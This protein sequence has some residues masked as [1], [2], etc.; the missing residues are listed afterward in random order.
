MPF[1]LLSIQFFAIYCTLSDGW[2]L[3][4]TAVQLGHPSAKGVYEFEL[5]VEPKL[6]MSVEHEH[7]ELSIHDYEPDGM[8][9]TEREKSQLR[10]C[11][12]HHKLLSVSPSTAHRQQQNRSSVLRELAL[13]A[14][15]ALPGLIQFNGRHNRLS[16]V[17]GQ[18]PGPTLVVPEGAE[19][20]IRLKNRLLLE[21]LAIHFHGQTMNNSWFHDGVAPIQQC[22]VA[23]R[24]DFDF[25]FTAHPAGTH[26]YHGHFP[27]GHQSDG[28]VGAFIVLPKVQQRQRQFQ[29]DYVTILQDWPLVSS[30]EQEAQMEEGSADF[31][32]GVHGDFDGKHL[33]RSGK[34]NGTWTILIN[35]KGWHSP[36]DIRQKPNKLQW[37]TFRVDEGDRIRFRLIHAGFQRPLVVH[38][39][40]HQMEVIAT[41]GSDVVPFRTDA[42]ILY[43]GERFDVRVKALTVP[44][45]PIYRMVVGLAEQFLAE[46]E[47]PIYGLADLDYNLIGEAIDRSWDGKRVDFLLNRCTARPCVL[48][49]CPFGTDGNGTFTTPD[50][51]KFKCH[52]VDEFRSN[53]KSDNYSSKSMV[54]CKLLKSSGPLKNVL[55]KERSATA[56]F[57]TRKETV[58]E[59]L[60]A[61]N[62]SSPKC[63]NGT[64]TPCPCF[65]HK[66]FPL[67]KTIQ[68]I[69]VNNN[70]N[71]NTE[72]KGAT[73]AAANVLRRSV[74]VHVHGTRFQVQQIA[75]PRL[76]GNGKVIIPPLTKCC[77]TENSGDH[78]AE[79]VHN[80]VWKDTVVVP[81][82]GHTVIRFYAQNAGWWTA[83]TQQNGRGFVRF[84]FAVGGDD[85]MTKASEE[86][87]SD[88]DVFDPGMEIYA[89]FLE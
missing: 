65:Y 86:F 47:E 18:S 5:L 37:T 7:G 29:K 19:V 4:E 27:G 45:R 39:E 52:S 11:L 61:G 22:P 40:H 57:S 70:N 24:S 87:P 28:L 10:P 1:S 59:A 43:P 17:N 48:M 14:E 15:R 35:G 46:E 34:E 32:R 41:D 85:Q 63:S 75:A 3:Y 58:A 2:S 71:N 83:E 79:N 69:F 76:L 56:P 20:L 38:I 53:G 54:F 89:K 73:F 12:D 72:Q 36:K 78:A 80:A 55:G 8:A 49:G 26:W 31:V 6:S 51:R 74:S 67:G 68:I 50:G 81:Y 62:C 66:R 60:R 23:V 21:S 9:W 33:E 84:A 13:H 88:C 77:G 42:L 82:G 25:R 44:R 64:R 16:V 30:W